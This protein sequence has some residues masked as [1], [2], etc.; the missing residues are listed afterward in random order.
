M[1]CQSKEQST[2]KRSRKA[3]TKKTKKL[4]D[5]AQLRE[6]EINSNSE[7]KSSPGKNYAEFAGASGIDR[8][9]NS[10]RFGCEVEELG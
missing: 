6:A 3:Y 8:T 9:T 2:K 5:E 1:D 4:E 7:K 10:V